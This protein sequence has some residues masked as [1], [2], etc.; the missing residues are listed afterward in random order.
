[1]PRLRAADAPVALCEGHLA[2]ASEWADRA[3][4]RDRS[5]ARR[6]AALCGSPLGVRYPSGWICAVC[7][8]RHGEVPDAELPPPR[9]DIVYYLRFGDRVKIGTTSNPRQRFAAIWH[10]EILAF[11]RGDRMLEH[12]R[13][14]AV[15][16]RG[17][18]AG[19]EWFRLSDALRTHI[20]V[21]GGGAVGIP[22]LAAI[23]AMGQRGAALALSRRTPGRTDAVRPQPLQSIAAI[24]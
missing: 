6:R 1:M 22:W 2:A 12:R 10:D 17:A 8:W 4:R 11:E 16:S 20:D 14:V 9:V 19:T 21:R 5:A 24:A 13:H 7:E 23:A 15:R 3:L 18:S